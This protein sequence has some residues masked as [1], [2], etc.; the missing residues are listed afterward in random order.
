MTPT[1]E[2]L[3]AELKR[4]VFDI[5]DKMF[6]LCVRDTEEETRREM[7]KFKTDLIKNC[8]DIRNKMAAVEAYESIKVMSFEEIQEMADLLIDDDDDD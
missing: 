5:M 8:K 6:K 2:E 7:L 4:T 3:E 1:K